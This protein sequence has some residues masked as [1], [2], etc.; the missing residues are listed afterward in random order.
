MEETPPI[1]W[2]VPALTTVHWLLAQQ[3]PGPS[4]AH[5]AGVQGVTPVQ[6]PP[7]STQSQLVAWTQFP[8]RQQR[9]K[10]GVVGQKPGAQDAPGK[11]V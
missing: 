7:L 1:C 6:V 4:P 10:T 2:Q 5:R 8:L 3:A 9:P 11:K